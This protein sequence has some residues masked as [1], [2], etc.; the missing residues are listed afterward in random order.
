VI[1]HPEQARILLATHPQL[2]YAL[3]QALLLNNI[4]DPSSVQVHLCVHLQLAL[5]KSK[6][7][8]LGSTGQGPPPPQ[9]QPMTMPAASYPPSNMPS[10]GYPPMPPSTSMQQAHAPS[11]PTSLPGG[12]YQ[13]P[14]PM[15]PPPTN[16]YYRPPPQMQPTMHPAAHVQPPSTPTAASAAVVD[17]EQRVS[18]LASLCTMCPHHC[19]QAM[20]IRVLNMTPEEI[21]VLPPTEQETVRMLVQVLPL[22]QHYIRSRW[23]VSFPAQSA[24]GGSGRLMCSLCDFLVYILTV[25]QKYMRE[26]QSS[27]LCK[28][29]SFFSLRRLCATSSSLMTLSDLPLFPI[30]S[31]LRT[32]TDRLSSSC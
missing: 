6:Q 32:L 19:E 15:V 16:G 8:M 23:V 14:P 31:R 22:S 7:R 3:S 18:S 2:D 28:L 4:L 20:L 1:T 29:R 10:Q 24:H 21:A 9:P 30:S 13:Q 5:A 25:K 27:L 17:P 12:M 26:H 11:H